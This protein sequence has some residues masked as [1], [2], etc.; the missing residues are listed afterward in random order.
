MDINAL[1][2]NYTYAAMQVAGLNYV[3]TQDVGLGG[4]GKSVH[5]NIKYCN[6]NQ[7]FCILPQECRS[8]TKGLNEHVD[9]PTQHCLF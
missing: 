3:M 6:L 7:G 9:C 1:A 5:E 4:V 8:G 2:P